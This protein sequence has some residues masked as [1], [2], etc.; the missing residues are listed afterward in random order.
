MTPPAALISEIASREASRTE[1]SEID[2][3]PLRECSTPT[4]IPPL[5]LEPLLLPDEPPSEP[6]QA[7][8]SAPSAPAA[9]SAAPARRMPRRDIRESRG[10]VWPVLSSIGE[11]P[12]L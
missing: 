9:L 3:V 10:P 11:L 1:T 12:F 2:M 6:P 7:I 8:P 5:E 4:L